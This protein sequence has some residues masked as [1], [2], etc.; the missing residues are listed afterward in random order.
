MKVFLRAASSRGTG[1]CQDGSETGPKLALG[2][3][4][5]RNNALAGARDH[6]RW[7]EGVG[8]GVK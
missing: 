1:P 6:P 7:G 5:I 3:R 8:L 4:V 2:A